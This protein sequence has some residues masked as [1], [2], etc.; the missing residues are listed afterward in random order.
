MFDD[1]VNKLIDELMYVDSCF[2]LYFHLQNL[3]ANEETL[4]IMNIA[5][6]FFQ[7]TI[8]SLLESS[9]ITLAKL[10]SNKDDRSIIRFIKYVEQ[11]SEHIIG[12]KSINDLILKHKSELDDNKE[13]IKYLFMWRNK[14]YAHYDKQYFF[15]S[16]QL[17]ID[18]PLLIGYINKLIALGGKIV[19]DY[20]VMS[21]GKYACISA[22]NR[23]DIDHLL[24]RVK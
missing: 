21:C 14:S 22:L 10:Y 1:Y 16:E 2:G 7:I 20:Q 4:N 24:R 9:I 6:G 3:K 18:A 19:N 13:A 17:A 5:P 8:R 11:N 12:G 23:F 15:D